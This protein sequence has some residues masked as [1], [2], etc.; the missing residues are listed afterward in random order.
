MLSTITQRKGETSHNLNGLA[1][2]R[3]QISF[4]FKVDRNRLEF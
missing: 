3:Q 2:M 4:A 1:M